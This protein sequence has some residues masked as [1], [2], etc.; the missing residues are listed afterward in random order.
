TKKP[1]SPIW[2]AGSVETL[3]GF[4]GLRCLADHPQSRLYSAASPPEEAA[5]KGEPI[6]SNQVHLRRRS[7]KSHSSISA[8]RHA[9]QAPRVGK[10]RFLAALGM[11]PT[12]SRYADAH[13]QE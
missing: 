6:I 1:A 7:L 3:C 13:R 10:S 8:V 12:S 11:T 9:C 5:R 4:F 2:G